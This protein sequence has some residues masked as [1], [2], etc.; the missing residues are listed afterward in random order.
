MLVHPPG[1][2][3]TKRGRILNRYNAILL[4]GP[5]GRDNA[6][7][8]RRN[9]G[10]DACQHLLRIV[11]TQLLDALRRSLDFVQAQHFPLV[12]LWPR[13]AS[14]S[15][16]S[17]GKSTGAIDV[18]F[19]FAV[20]NRQISQSPPHH[21]RRLP[22]STGRRGTER[23]ACAPWCHYLKGNIGIIYQVRIFRTF[24]NLCIVWCSQ[25]LHARRDNLGASTVR[26]VVLP[27]SRAQ[28]A[29][30]EDFPPLPMP[31][32]SLLTLALLVAVSLVGRDQEIH[33]RQTGGRVTDFR[34][35]P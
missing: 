15:G 2:L 35:L 1:S 19:E 3:V 17:Q 4:C 22:T 8:K 31:L 11:G 26:G 7:I 34:V 12:T 25:E 21:R 32:C 33:D 6:G 18:L 30:H 28:P 16:S 24:L 5:N 23:F 13:P 29:L 20:S 9:Q 27:L 14:Y 10:C